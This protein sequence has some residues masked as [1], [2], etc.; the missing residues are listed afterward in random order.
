[1][2]RSKTGS[3]GP[4]FEYWAARPGNR[5]GGVLSPHGDKRH[6]KRTHKMERRLNK[7]AARET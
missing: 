3:K 1:M 7:A 6:K 2:S 4:G 5:G